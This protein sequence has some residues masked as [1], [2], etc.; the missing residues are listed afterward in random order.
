MQAQARI[1]PV[2]Y[3]DHSAIYACEND[4]L[5]EAIATRDA[6][7]ERLRGRL[8]LFEELCGYMRG[9][10]EV[11]R[12]SLPLRVAGEPRNVDI[13]WHTSEDSLDLFD[14]A[15]AL[16]AEGRRRDGL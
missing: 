12:K 1:C 8:A 9:P 16:V 13:Y 10:I 4:N 5:L 2:C 11:A 14:A 7:I 6:E 15:V 3:D